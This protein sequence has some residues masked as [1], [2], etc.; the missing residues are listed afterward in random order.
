MANAFRMDATN[1]L[2]LD[3]EARFVNSAWEEDLCS[4]PKVGPATKAALAA[5]GIT[6]T[7][8]LIGQFLMFREPGDNTQQRCNAMCDFL[9]GAGVSKALMHPIT[10][11]L[12]KKLDRQFPCVPWRTPPPPSPLP[13]YAHARALTTPSPPSAQRLL[14]GHRV[15]VK[16]IYYLS[17]F[18]CFL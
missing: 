10:M 16:T 3:E 11:A 17:P 7:Y 18:C 5:A 14:R 15:R 2:S 4:I 8:K 1:A 12:A 13:P 6:T 9:V